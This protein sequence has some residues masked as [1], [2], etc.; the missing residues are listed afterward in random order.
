MTVQGKFCWAYL[1]L[2]L[3][4]GVGYYSTSVAA[5]TQADGLP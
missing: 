3:I 1:I 5:Q 2:A 4:F